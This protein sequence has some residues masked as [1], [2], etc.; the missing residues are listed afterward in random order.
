MDIKRALW[1]GALSWILIFFEVSVLMFG[2]GITDTDTRLAHHLLF[3]AI[4][5]VCAL[6]YFRK[7]TIKAGAIEGL[8]LCLIFFGVSLFLDAAIT[9]PLFVKDYSFLANP[10][11]LIGFAES[12]IVTVAVGLMRRDKR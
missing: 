12:L 11:H 8:Y 1:T 10:Y 7:S 4:I 3:S 9:I 2:F 5:L 6:L